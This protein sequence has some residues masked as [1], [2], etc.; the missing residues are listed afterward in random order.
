MVPLRRQIP[1]DVFNPFNHHFELLLVAIFLG[2]ILRADRAAAKHYLLLIM[3]G[4]GYRAVA[5]EL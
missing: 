1:P 5:R 4:C 2:T 3:A